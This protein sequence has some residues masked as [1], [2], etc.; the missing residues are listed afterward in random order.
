MIEGIEVLNTNKCID[1]PYIT[2]ILALFVIISI[3]FIFIGTI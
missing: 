1:V 2:Y 3:L